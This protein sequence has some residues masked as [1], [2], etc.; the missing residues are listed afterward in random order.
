MIKHI[1]LWTLKPNAEGKS[2]EENA[3][4]M[5]EKLEGLYGKIPEII[6]IQIQANTLKIEGNYDVSL[7]AEFESEDDMKIY[8]KHP[9]HEEIA[10]YVRGIAEKRA[11]V[12]FEY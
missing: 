6:S 8:Q 2:I 10:A 11:A 1:V 12:D 7:I 3:A 4:Y 5:K 9:L